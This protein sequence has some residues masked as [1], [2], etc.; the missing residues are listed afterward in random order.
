MSPDD[1][2]PRIVGSWATSAA[3]RRTMLGNKRRDTKPELEIRRRLHALG[4]RYRV[5][6]RLD[7][8]S[9]TRA[10]IVFTRR[11]VA[12]FV[13]GCFWHGCPMHG[14]TPKS[15]V[16]YWGPKLQRNQERDRTTNTRLREMGWLVLRFWEH[17]DPDEVADTILAQWTA[18]DPASRTAHH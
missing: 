6:F 10:D 7:A 5:D 9:R 12:V 2:N 14:V 13:D 17:E 18:M 4:L 15:N 3:T 8:S 1:L 16:D 11:R